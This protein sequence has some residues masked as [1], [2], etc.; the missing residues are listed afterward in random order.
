MKRFVTFAAVAAAALLCTAC[1]GGSSGGGDKQVIDPPEP[2]FSA[3]LMTAEVDHQYFPLV[4]G[5]TLSYTGDA[6]H[7]VEVFV[8]HA[9]RMVAQVECTE[10]VERLFRNEELV[11]ERFAWFAQDTDGNV[12]LLGEQITEYSGGSAVSTA[13]SWET[14]VD[15]AEPGILLKAV[16]VVGDTY[17]QEFLAGEAEDM[18]EV[19][20]VDVPVALSNGTAHLCLKTREWSP[21]DPDSV[22]I[23]YYAQGTNLVLEENEAGDELTEL[24]DVEQDVAPKLDP[25]DFVIGVDNPLFPLVPGTTHTYEGVTENGTEVIQAYVT[26]NTKTLMGV[27]C[28]EV[29]VSETIDGELSEHTLDWYAQDSAGNVWYFGEHAVH[30]QNGVPVNVEGSWQA[31]VDGGQPGIVMKAEP[32][33]GDTY[34]QEYSFGE[35]EDLAEVT[36]VDVPVTLSDGTNYTCLQTRDWTPLEAEAD[37]T[38]YYA[39]GVGMVK[40]TAL[41]GSNA[42]ELK[43]VTTE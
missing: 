41:D 23:K 15:G 13:G 26:H 21:L 42:L 6:N 34:R 16:P 33:L 8:S 2:A 22:E 18:S 11:E 12:W 39:P 4:P 31:G 37:E 25:A 40:E 43:S 17:R 36:G 9:T 32:R 10:L 3:A 5:T 30:Y 7:S 27:V 20:G 29:D 14:G 38:K 24:V 19:V 28:I 35:A 1:G